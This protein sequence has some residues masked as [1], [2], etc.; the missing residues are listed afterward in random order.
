MGLIK[1]KEQFL[2]GETG[3]YQNIPFDE[4]QRL[5]A[6]NSTS[7][8]EMSYSPLHCYYAFTNGREDTDALSLGRTA[9]AAIF[10]PERFKNFLVVPEFTGLTKD[11]KESTRS[12]EAIEKKKKWLEQHKDSEFVE[13]EEY[14]TAKELAESCYNHPATKALLE[15]KSYNEL[16]GVWRDEATGLLCKIRIDRLINYKHQD[17]VYPTIL[18]AKTFSKRVISHNVNREIYDRKYYFQKAFYI[19]GVNAI[20]NPENKTQSILIFVE[21]QSP[22]GVLPYQLGQSW[23]V[24]GAWEVNDALKRFKE[25]QDKG[26]WAGYESTI[27]QSTPPSWAFENL[28]GQ[29]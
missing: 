8:K 18:D 23:I 22:H 28:Q 7:L 3:F 10:E 12:A 17:K 20:L 29:I 11:G 4:Y 27:V 19:K 2:A 9:H 5:K 15:T 21:T 24:A 13:Q 1:T 6:V 26:E 16:T 25:C 14:D